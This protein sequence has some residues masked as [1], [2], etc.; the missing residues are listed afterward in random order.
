LKSR[1]LHVS[2]KFWNSAATA[3]NWRLTIKNLYGTEVQKNAVLTHIVM[4][5]KCV[6]SFFLP[7][8]S[9]LWPI[10]ARVF[11]ASLTVTMITILLIM[12][13]VYGRIVALI[14]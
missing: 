12:M 14:N 2:S 11:E 4:V 8:G 9:L 13:M 7:V 10:V 6:V 1:K 5:V 3:G